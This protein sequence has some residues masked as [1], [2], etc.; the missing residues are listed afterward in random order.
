MISATKIPIDRPMIVPVD[1]GFPSFSL[2]VVAY[3]DRANTQRSSIV[4]DAGTNAE[5][6]SWPEFGNRG[7]ARK[8]LQDESDKTKGMRKLGPRGADLWV[9]SV[10]R[11]CTK[12]TNETEEMDVDDV[13]KA[14]GGEASICELG[15]NC[16]VRS[17]EQTLNRHRSLEIALNLRMRVKK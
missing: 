2:S 9:M 3:T 4:S 10:S 17:G 16:G 13:S 11:N 7:D 14:G 12:S 1:V 8:A 5:R 6:G 15:F